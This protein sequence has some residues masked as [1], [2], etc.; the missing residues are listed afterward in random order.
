MLRN[1][2]GNCFYQGLLTYA[3]Y[4]FCQVELQEMRVIIKNAI[5]KTLPQ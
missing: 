2:L 3:N 1:F 5:E 4:I